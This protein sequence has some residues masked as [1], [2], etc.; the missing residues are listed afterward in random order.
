MTLYTPNTSIPDEQWGPYCVN[1]PETPCAPA[2]GTGTQR[3]VYTSARSFHPGGVNVAFGDA[4][5]D[6]I[7]DSVSV[8]YWKAISTMNGQEILGD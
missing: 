2:S 4:H 3:E 6:F 1:V 7:S 5:V 8:A